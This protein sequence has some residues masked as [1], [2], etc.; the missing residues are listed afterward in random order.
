MLRY[1]R[2]HA[3]SWI[4]KILLGLIIVVFVF[5]G[6]GRMKSKKE[7]VMATVGDTLI[8]IGQFDRSYRDLLDYYTQ[9]F[10]QRLSPDLLRNLNMKQ[11]VLEQLVTTALFHEAAQHLGILVSTEE[12]KNA[13]VENPAFQ[14]EGRF[15]RDLYLDA[16][17]RSG[18]DTGS[19]EEMLQRDLI[20]RRAQGLVRDTA[21]MIPDRELRDLY[22]FENEKITLSFVKVTPESFKDKTKVDQKE[23]KQYF[24]EHKEEFRSRPK[25]KVDYLRFSPTDFMGE[26]TVSPGEI[27]DYYADN[28]ERYRK[29]K[30]ARVRQILV[31]VDRAAEDDEKAQAREKA[32]KVL[33]EAGKEADFAEL[34]RKHSDDLSASR[35][36]DMGYVAQGTL[37]PAV[38][39]VIFALGKGEISPI[40]ETE[41]GF[42]IFKV[43]DVQE[44][45]VRPL[46]EVKDEVI[47]RL[48]NEKA[49]D[50]AAIHAE[51][52]AYKA[53]KRAVLEAYA[54]AEGLTVN[55][56]GP[57]SPGDSIEGLGRRKTFSSTAFS[58]SKGEISP[59]VQD[60]EDYFVLSV[61]D[62]IPPQLP[63][64][65]QIEARVREAFVS[66][67]TKEIA[68]ETA[69]SLLSAWKAGDGFEE[70][71]AKNN[72]KLEKTEFFTRNADTAPGIGPL[73][74]Y[75]DEISTL[76][77][78]DPWFPE[79][80]E[81][82]GSYFV[83]K[84]EEVQ[85]ADQQQFGKEQTA[86]QQRLEGLEAGV[87]LQRWA[88]EM[89]EQG[90]VK[91]NQE[92]L[93]RYR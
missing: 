69:G 87:M 75:A 7:T 64:Y 35:G 59:A 42:T 89:R 79:M 88:M 26:V 1:M 18:L 30:R 2:T 58:L 45:T 8:T 77:F 25:V 44:E 67:R 50:L 39:R 66:L 41:R 34:A 9:I 16:L 28:I 40:V 78:E 61:V 62:K 80:A 47:S 92:L 54:E 19:F 53:K 90:T 17:V 20:I 86:Y 3:T 81:L 73:S 49:A 56:A 38:D 84:L 57:F 46:E 14:R 93:D 4:I 23:L 60:G 12:V 83:I 72:L 85:K 51:D 33:E 32:E 82:A 5:W 22:F 65:E 71:L 70:L 74:Q 52:A 37:L 31:K 36:G 43:E 63:T 13:I 29:P 24:A 21:V 68:Q 6:M 10:G 76:T 27:E 48:K 11:Q 91:I 15:I 55:E